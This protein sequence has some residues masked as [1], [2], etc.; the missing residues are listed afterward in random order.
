[1]ADV[2]SIARKMGTTLITSG[3]KMVKSSLDL[4]TNQIDATKIAQA[5]VNVG[6]G[7]LPMTPL[8]SDYK[9]ITWDDWQPIL[10]TL[11]DIASYFPWTAEYFDCDQRAS[12]VKALADTFTGINSMGL[13]YVN[14]YHSKTGVYLTRHWVD[15]VLTTDG[16]LHIFDIDNNGGTITEM[17]KGQLM[18]G[19]NWRYE[20]IST[21]WF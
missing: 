20:I 11:K 18:V 5:F 13:A 15:M 10:G 9:T 8:D 16:K 14:L 1:M 6:L 19:G 17:A 7:D 21:R 4:I 2:N 3:I 12:F